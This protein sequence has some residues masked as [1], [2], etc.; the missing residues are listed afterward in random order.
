[1]DRVHDNGPHTPISTQFFPKMI[2]LHDH[3]P[4]REMELAVRKGEKVE[5]VK[6][7]P[8]W[9][10]V[11][12]E[13]G[14]EGYVP[15]RNCVPPAITRRSRSNSRSS[16]PV[17]S[18]M[19]GE[20]LEGGVE[21]S[22]GGVPMF[23]SSSAGKVRRFDS[24]MDSDPESFSIRRVNS[25]PSNILTPSSVV[26]ETL[27]TENS[28]TNMGTKCSL[29]SSSGVASLMDPSSPA[30]TRAFS[31]DELKPYNEESTM[32]S[33]SQSAIEPND[34]GYN[35]SI[36][37]FSQTMNAVHHK[38]SSSDDSGTVNSTPLK[39]DEYAST[40]RN[41]ETSSEEGGIVKMDQVSSGGNTPSMK[42]RPLPTPPFYDRPNE[43]HIFNED[44]PP[45]VPPR[46][47][48]L[49]SSKQRR[50]SNSVPH[51]QSPPV[52][53]DDLSPYAQPV[54]SIV[55]GPTGTSKALSILQQQ[56]QSRQYTDTTDITLQNTG[57]DSPYSE[58]YR[59]PQ[60][61]KR[62]VNVQDGRGSPVV[63]RRS[64]PRNVQS[65]LSPIVRQ[66]SPLV[67]GSDHTPH[68]PQ[69]NNEMVNDPQSKGV[70]KFRKF[71]WGV[72]MCMKVRG[73]LGFFF[74]NPT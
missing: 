31:Q 3:Y 54:D 63:N 17:R 69:F 2:V 10:F 22:R 4:F 29:S 23:S 14:K 45:P 74:F 15:A 56:S 9:L 36:I 67:N 20:I 39:D 7:E 16:I 5:V 65:T 19:S 21:R 66:T 26:G 62:P 70:A 30:M 40:I 1:M 27:S 11:R 41:D 33:L 50:T 13:R 32:F 52:V 8:E 25:P 24:P 44:T 18:V 58:V 37:E 35:K 48:S 28:T 53:P 49:S 71:Q 46:N 55:S 6:K 34:T 72:F 64:L 60:A 51:S 61:N 38:H 43:S 59:G 73:F 12:N 42:D 57:V 68:S 47:A